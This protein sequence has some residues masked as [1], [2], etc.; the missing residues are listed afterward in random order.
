[1]ASKISSSSSSS[2]PAPRSCLCSPTTHLGSFRCS[3]HRSYA[4]S[5]VTANLNRSESSAKVSSKMSLVKAFLL[6]IIRPSRHHL[7][8]RRSFHPKPTRFSVMNCGST[9]DGVAV[10]S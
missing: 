3:R 6:Q 7:H 9:R 8:R 4:P 5:K 2:T 1:M 10:N